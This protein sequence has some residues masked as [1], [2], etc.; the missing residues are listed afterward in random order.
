MAGMKPLGQI[1]KDRNIV[2]ATTTN[3]TEDTTYPQ[4]PGPPMP[5][6]WANV[7]VSPTLR[8]RAES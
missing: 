2:L 1:L 8:V 5:P 4:W 3:N 6:G 7:P